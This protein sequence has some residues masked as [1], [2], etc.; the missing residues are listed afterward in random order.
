ME[1]EE[2]ELLLFLTSAIDGEVVIVT[3]GPK[4]P[5]CLLGWRL[6]SVLVQRGKNLLPLSGIEPRFL[7]LQHVA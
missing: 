5:R 3:F 4:K 7:D 6:G 1:G 2:L